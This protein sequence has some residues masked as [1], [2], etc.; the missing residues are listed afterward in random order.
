MREGGGNP[1]VVPETQAEVR[2]G[3]PLEPHEVEAVLAAILATVG[4]SAEAMP[5]RV[6]R[7]QLSGFICVR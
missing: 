4:S 7:E 1:P 5:L 3:R 6:V 2:R